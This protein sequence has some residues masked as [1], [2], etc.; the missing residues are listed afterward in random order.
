MNPI[1]IKL[2]DYVSRL[3]S[4]QFNTSLK[5]RADEKIILFRK[6]IIYIIGR[7]RVITVFY[8]QHSSSPLLKSS[9]S[10]QPYNYDRS[11]DKKDSLLEN[12]SNLLE[13]SSTKK[14]LNR[15]INQIEIIRNRLQQ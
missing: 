4:A 15:K 13:K 2:K 3:L 6:P 1:L 11:K 10:L 8:Y 12:G 5:S 7:K 14:S 9:V